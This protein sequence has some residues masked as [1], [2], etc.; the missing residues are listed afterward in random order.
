MYLRTFFDQLDQ[1]LCAL[2][3]GAPQTPISLAAAEA[4]VKREPWGC[5]LCAWLHAT[6]RQQHC[7][8]V[9][10]GET[11]T[12]FA[13]VSAAVQLAVLAW[14]IAAIGVLGPI[15]VVLWLD[16]MPLLR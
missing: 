3:G 10:A 2:F 7:P 16:G 4:E 11:T 9:L 1:M 6:L 5:A 13:A 14:V 15:A 8:R 12:G